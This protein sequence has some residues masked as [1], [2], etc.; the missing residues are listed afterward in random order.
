MP[1]LSQRSAVNHSSY[2]GHHRQEADWNMS[3][4]NFDQAYLCHVLVQN[5]FFHSRSTNVLRFQSWLL[6]ETL[7]CHL[8][9]A[10]L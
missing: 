6:E 5:A 7:M 2:Q 4:N 10:S 1:L 8:F 3:E 9:L